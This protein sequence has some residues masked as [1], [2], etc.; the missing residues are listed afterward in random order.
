[1][2]NARPSG[3]T[4]GTT[5]S[6]TRC[7]AVRR[8]ARERPVAERQR[9]AVAQR[10]EQRRDEVHGD[11]ARPPLARV[12]VRL[13]IEAVARRLA[14]RAD[15]QQ[16]HGPAFARRLG[17]RRDRHLVLK[18]LGEELALRDDLVDRE[19]R[20]RQGLRLA[21]RTRASSSA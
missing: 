21:A 8:G 6:S 11:V 13:D 3:F 1:M 15:A 14:A 7:I 19:I 2:L 17:Q 20:H 10:D 18:Q 5:K 4:H 16:V 12:D 9:R